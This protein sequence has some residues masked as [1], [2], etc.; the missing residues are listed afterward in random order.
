MTMSSLVSQILDQ[1]GHIEDILRSHGLYSEHAPEASALHS[2]MPF[3]CDQMQF[4]QWLQWVLIPKTR[5]LLAENRVPPS[6]NHIYAMAETELAGLSQDTDELLLA[7]RTLDEM[8][9]QLD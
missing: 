9:R 2:D 5:Q 4:H 3:C 7:I 8:F 6:Q 1:L